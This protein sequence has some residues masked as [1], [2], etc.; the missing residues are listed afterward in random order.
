[1]NNKAQILKV[2]YLYFPAWKFGR[3]HKAI[4]TA[5]AR[6]TRTQWIVRAS[7][8]TITKN[9]GGIHFVGTVRFYKDTGRV[10]G[11]TR[12]GSRVNTWRLDVTKTN[13]AQTSEPIDYKPRVKPSRF[14]IYSNRGKVAAPTALFVGDF[15]ELVNKYLETLDPHNEDEMFTTE[16]CMRAYGLEGF[17]VWLRKRM[18]VAK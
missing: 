11:S 10:V 3:T 12:L 7:D 15:S 18:R 8:V 14:E 16:R 9:T 2:V 6:E 17:T 4:A 5:V 1:M 13:D